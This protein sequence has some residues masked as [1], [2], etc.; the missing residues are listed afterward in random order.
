MDPTGSYYYPPTPPTPPTGAAATLVL[1]P[2]VGTIATV[3][4]NPVSPSVGPLTPPVI[5]NDPY[6]GVPPLSVYGGSPPCYGP[7]ASVNGATT[8]TPSGSGAPP[9]QTPSAATAAAP[10]AFLAILVIGGI[11][12]YALSRSH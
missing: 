12:A 2:P 5:T 11:A 3:A 8:T 7:P 6:T 1:P 4:N 10:S 9:T